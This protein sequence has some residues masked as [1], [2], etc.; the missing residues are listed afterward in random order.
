MAWGR[1]KEAALVV[2]GIAVGATVAAYAPEIQD[3]FTSW[4]KTVQGWRGPS[5]KPINTATVAGKVA[6]LM[7]GA[8]G[9]AYAGPNQVKKPQLGF[10]Q[11]LWNFLFGVR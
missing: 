3:T 4:R 6:T 7:G 5:A 10:F 1:Y 9:T 2:G 11:R 8:P